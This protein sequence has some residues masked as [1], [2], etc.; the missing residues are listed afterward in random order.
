MYDK[1]A[2]LILFIL[3]IKWFFILLLI[4]FLERKFKFLRYILSFFIYPFMRKI[5]FRTIESLI[6]FTFWC[7]P[8]RP[9]QIKK[10]IIELLKIVKKENCKTLIEIGTAKGGTL[11]LFTRVVS[12]DAILISID[13]PKGK[14]GG[15]YSVFRIPLYKSFKYKNQKIF[16]LRENF[17]EYSTFEEVKKI[18]GEK[19]ADV[20][21]IDGDHT[22]YGVKKDFEMYKKLVKNGGLII[23]HDIF[24]HT[25]DSEVEVYRFWNEIKDKYDV[26]EICSKEKVS[27]GIGI[28]R[29]EDRD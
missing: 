10:E 7:R 5:K 13:L 2:S 16:L 28:I 14:F 11:F 17:H 25:F 19:K 18:L 23:F 3:K 21:F 22:Y 27:Y 8:I 24:S 20:L 6:S 12:P 4:F 15:G 9:M 1:I 29:N 26:I